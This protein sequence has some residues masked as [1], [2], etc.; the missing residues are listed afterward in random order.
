M[1]SPMLCGKV[2]PDLA[3]V[4]I[5]G[6]ERGGSRIRGHLRCLRIPGVEIPEYGDT[7]AAGVK[8]IALF[9]VVVQFASHTVADR[10]NFRV[11]EQR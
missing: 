11:R 6:D 5:H 10:S 7:K 1:H 2:P 4:H 9:V 3:I 8:S